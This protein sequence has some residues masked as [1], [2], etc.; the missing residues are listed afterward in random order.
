[1]R[2]QPL[3][4]YDG[5]CAFCTTWV[6]RLERWLVRFP[7]AQPSQWLDLDELGLSSAEVTRYVWL[8]VG[9]RRFR[10]HAAFAALLRMQRSW[11]LR[12]A[13]QLLVTPPFSWAAALGYALV[14]RFR[15]RLPGG[16]AAC[17]LP[18]SD[19]R[20]VSGLAKAD[21]EPVPPVEL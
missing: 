1:M 19:S 10:G 16:T 11:I 8:L 20:D 18:R 3:L 4:V 12:V 9:E 7:D 13:G 15:H 5:D 6:R 17:A 14:A 2:P 21:V